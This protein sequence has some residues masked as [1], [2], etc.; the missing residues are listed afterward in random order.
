MKKENMSFKILLS[1]LREDLGVIIQM[2][3]YP[4]HDAIASAYGLYFLLK[5]R[6]FENVRM[7]YFGSISNFSL[8]EIV[9]RFKIP[10][11]KVDESFKFSKTDQVVIVDS[12][13]G[14][15]NV[16]NLNA[17][18]IGIIDHHQ[19]PYSGHIC[20]Y[21]DLKTDYGSC[22]TII[23][24]YFTEENVRVPKDIASMLLL[25]IAVDTSFLTRNVS[26]SDVNA[27]GNLYFLA[28]SANI[29]KMLKKSFSIS[30]ISIFKEAMQNMDIENH[31]CFVSIKKECSPDLLAVIADFFLSLKEV[32]F[33]V[34]LAPYKN[35][36][37]VSLRSEDKMR[38]TELIVKKALK[39]IGHGGGHVYMGAGS[40]P[41]DL[42]LGFDM[43][44]ERF[45]SVLKEIDDNTAKTDS[46]NDSN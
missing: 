22:S 19:M 8:N 17:N 21:Q 25:G 37:R 12:F 29:I 1:F 3:D 26:K 15:S 5:T 32:R 4:D 36:Y 18:L 28:D 43:I 33:V 23:Y 20:P 38:S 44:K 11:Q 2:H 41:R 7:A 35:S 14:N 34:V 9:D 24:E 31:F 16:T 46:L 40:I 30:H 42:F 27:Y 6:G 13:F 10:I 45:K 39:G